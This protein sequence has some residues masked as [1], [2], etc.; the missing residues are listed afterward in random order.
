MINDSAAWAAGMLFGS[1]NRGI[2]PAS[3]NKSVAGFIG[4][5]AAAV[6]AGLGGVLL[7]PAVFAPKLLPPL[8]SGLILGLF[9]GAAASLG[10]LMESALKRSSGIKDSGSII[11][12][13]GGVLD[14]I[15]SIALAAPVFYAVYRILFGP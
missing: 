10:D 2:I 15:D 8:P 11:P 1:G 14:S 12:G 4:G 13:R 6:L 3:P 5:T 7:F 9:L